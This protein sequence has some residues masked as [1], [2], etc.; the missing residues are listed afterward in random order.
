MEK[1]NPN[2]WKDFILATVNED[3]KS[4]RVTKRDKQLIISNIDILVS[5]LEKVIA[6]N[7]SIDSVF[8]RT[9]N[10]CG[11]E[12]RTWVRTFY[13]L[14]GVSLYNNIFSSFDRNHAIRI[15]FTFQKSKVEMPLNNHR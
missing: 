2:R 9:V 6:D 5:A 3:M 11:T 10:P 4:T 15:A 8:Y 13:C 1:F 7:G 12:D 14:I